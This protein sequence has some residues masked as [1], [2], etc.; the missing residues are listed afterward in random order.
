MTIIKKAFISERAGL[1]VADFL[2][3]EVPLSK[4]KIKLAMHKGAVWLLASGTDEPQRVR[5]AKTLVKLGDEIHLYY[6][7][8]YLAID[9]PA[10]QPV[11][12]QGFVSFWLRPQGISSVVSLWGDH[13][14]IERL[15]ERDL[16]AD[17]DCYWLYPTEIDCSGLVIIAHSR[18]IASKLQ[19]AVDNQCC[20]K[21]Y[22]LELPFRLTAEVL[23]AKQLRLLD[24]RSLAFIE[25]QYLDYNNHSTLIFADVVDEE[26]L[27]LD[28]FVELNQ[29]LGLT[30]PQW[31]PKLH[32]CQITLTMFA[33]DDKKQPTQLSCSL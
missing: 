24:N 25:T 14:S 17:K 21:Q 32:C 7:S 20:K 2:A 15:I 28:S 4:A 26:Q 8:D 12:D 22:Q 1:S 30:D 5:R 23:T 10:L 19:A 18:N 16:P 27:L 33:T 31:M 9:L 13:L 29:Q 6:D 3:D 11:D